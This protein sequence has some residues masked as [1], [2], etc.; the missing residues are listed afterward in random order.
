MVS[1]GGGGGEGVSHPRKEDPGEVSEER[2]RLRGKDREIM[3]QTSRK[4]EGEG[5]AE[6]GERGGERRQIRTFRGG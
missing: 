1:R 3:P 5:F 2:G 4:N 6:R